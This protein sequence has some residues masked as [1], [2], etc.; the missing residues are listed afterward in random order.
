MA[1]AVSRRPLTKKNRVLSQTNPYKICGGQSR[2]GTNFVPSKAVVLYQYHSTNAPHPSS[3]TNMHCSYQKC[4]R[5]KTG[6][7][8]K[9]NALSEIGEYWKEKFFHLCFVFKGLQ[10]TVQIIFIYCWP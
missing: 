4:K 10:D 2:T 7:L 9:S 1:Q 8:P 6:N 5:A 3:S